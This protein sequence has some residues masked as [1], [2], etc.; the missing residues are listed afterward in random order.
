VGG[1]DDLG[2]DVGASRKLLMAPVPARYPARDGVEVMGPLAAAAAIGEFT[3]A[4]S[5]PEGRP[6]G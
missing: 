2:A 4:L 6:D 5:A 3:Q 1:K